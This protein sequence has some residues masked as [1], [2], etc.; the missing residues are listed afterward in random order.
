MRSFSAEISGNRMPGGELS[1]RQRDF[2]LA[3]AEAGAA[4]K[5]IANALRCTQRAVQKTIARWEAT[6]S[7]TT[8]DRTGRP[9]IFTSR[10]RRRLLRIAKKA[11]G[12]EYRE[13][14]KEAGLWDGQ[15]AY[16]DVSQ[17]TVQRALEEEG[18]RKFRAKRRPKINRSTAKQRLEFAQDWRSFNWRRETLK[19]SDECS[20]ARGYGHNT[21]WVWRLPADKWS[22][23][24][25][26][27]VSTAR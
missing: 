25:V 7:T 21:Q 22:H 20:L 10:D 4:T 23:K 26:E 6:S 9:P 15:E 17:R 19:F 16:P 5:E 27:E 1:E 14:L 8:R 18:Y 24:M 13:L 3:Q 12:I 11:T 2:I